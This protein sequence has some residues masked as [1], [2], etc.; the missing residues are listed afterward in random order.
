MSGITWMVVKRKSSD[1]DHPGRIIGGERGGVFGGFGRVGEELDDLGAS[2]VVLGGGLRGH[3]CQTG[4]GGFAVALGVRT[5]SQ[6]RGRVFLCGWKT[7]GH[8]TRLRQKLE[9]GAVDG[10][11]A[12]GRHG[13]MGE[14]W[15]I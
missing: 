9:G 6:R 13:I 1:N 5:G 3:C 15:G 12:R 8:V 7:L 2:R 4:Q 10:F 11:I 14:F